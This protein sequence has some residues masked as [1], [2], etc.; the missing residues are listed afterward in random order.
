MASPPGSITTV[1]G[2]R[3]TRSRARVAVTTPT[4]SA[5]VAPQQPLTTTTSSTVDAVAGTLS[6]GTLS[7]VLTSSSA[8][9]VPL[10]LPSP[11]SASAAQ[12]QPVAALATLEVPLQASVVAP[13]PTQESQN[14]RHSPSVTPDSVPT[15]SNPTSGA[16]P[17]SPVEVSNAP[18]NPT[19]LTVSGTSVSVNTNPAVPL[20]S[21]TSPQSSITASTVGQP[22][23]TGSPLAGS[24]GES[25]DGSN[26]IIGPGQG[27]SN[28][29]GPLTLDSNV[30]LA[31]ILGGVF[32]GIAAL[33]LIVGLL[34]LVLRK[35]RLK[36][37][38]WNEKRQS[39]SSL[40]SRIR[41]IPTGLGAFVARLKGSQTGS[42]QNPYQRHVPKASA[43]S[44]YSRDSNGRIRSNGEPQGAYPHR[45]ASSSGSISSKKS[46][47]NLLRKK[48]SSISAY[49]FPDIAEDTGTPNPFAD[50]QQMR[51]LLILNPDPRSTPTTPQVP[52]ATA[53]PEP[54]D[55]FT[56][57]YDPP[58][59]APM[60][61]RGPAQTHQ[62]AM[63]SISGQSSRTTWSLYPTANPF[64]DP[65]NVPPLPNQAV[66][67]Q[68]HRQRSSMA[69]PNFN[70]T[71]I[72]DANS[73]F[74]TRDSGL[75][76]GEPGPS[77]PATN[78]FTPVTPAR[79]TIRQS[80]PFDL[81]RPEVLGFGGLS[82][83]PTRTKRRSSVNNWYSTAGNGASNAPPLPTDSTRP[84]WGPNSG[85]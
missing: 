17:P 50:P 1:N 3:C 40:L 30:N 62:R 78:I 15:N 67:P 26:G 68:H 28:D 79:R 23:V 84:S 42:T 27:S 59:V 49:R 18:A 4:T 70:P 35:R 38:R 56:S 48:P 57:V 75:L 11:N 72:F 6:T 53:D 44:T 74:A 31:G 55:P 33:A 14:N 63:S 60:R 85:R 7:T 21:D 39:D 32:G 43:D 66:L 24:A 65:P 34:F 54:R 64:N 13:A 41:T 47:R 45:R 2:R 25:N 73:T 29:D 16:A 46:E 19:A 83:Q 76:F 80:D 10:A 82:R 71:A 58:P 37:R 36:P 69:L 61:E 22:R 77:R 51:P 9:V 81:D 5:A 20:E 12:E 8:R 52:A